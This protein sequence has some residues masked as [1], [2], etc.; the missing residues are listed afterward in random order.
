M[1]AQFNM[2]SA[3]IQVVVLACLTRMT[4]APCSRNRMVPGLKAPR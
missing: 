3:R 2:C 1:F 4:M